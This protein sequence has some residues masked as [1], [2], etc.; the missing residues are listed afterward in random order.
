MDDTLRR[1]LMVLAVVILTAALLLGG[2]ALGR[3]VWTQAFD[4]PP[5]I[6]GRPWRYGMMGPGMMGYGRPAGAGDFSCEG[7]GSWGGS[8]PEGTEGLSLDEARAAVERSLQ[9]WD[10]GDLETA[11]VMEFSNHFYALVREENSG[12]GAFELLVDRETGEVHPEPGPNMMWN[13]KYGMMG[14]GYGGMGMMG[15]Y[16]GGYGGMG[17]RG[18]GSQAAPSAGMPVDEARAV[19]LA[20]EYLDAVRPGSTAEEEADA[21][22]GYYTLHVL[23]DGEVIGMLSVNGYTG[24]VWYHTWHGVFV[25]MVGEGHG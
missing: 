15:G 22:Y 7:M 20:Q 25:D 21:F 4:G 6:G 2:L 11:E 12:V 19:E 23:A 8:Y 24:Q 13:Q 18:S 16:G 14:R 9:A 3:F 17:M 1:G 10:A 5:S